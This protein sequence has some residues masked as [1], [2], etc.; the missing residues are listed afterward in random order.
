MALS[1]A[2][3]FIRYTLQLDGFDKILRLCKLIDYSIGH[4]KG[5]YQSAD[6]PRGGHCKMLI[7]K[8][9]E[10]LVQIAF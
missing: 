4:W 9:K 6:I 1:Y 7:L 8:S 3:V 5:M 10:K 2:K